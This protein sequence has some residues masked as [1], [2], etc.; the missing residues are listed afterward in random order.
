MDLIEIF[1]KRADYHEARLFHFSTLKIP[2]Q[3][4]VM[5]LDILDDYLHLQSGQMNFGALD[6]AFMDKLSEYNNRVKCNIGY[7]L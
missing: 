1:K 5:Q 4:T 7:N 2:I 3:N 6:L